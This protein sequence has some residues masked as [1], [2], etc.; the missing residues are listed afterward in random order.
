MRFL[1][2]VAWRNIFRNKRRTV[3]ASLAIGIGLAAL[4]FTDGLIIGMSESMIRTATDT[5]LGHAQIHAAEFR[6]TQ[7]VE[8]TINDLPAV[9]SSLRSDPDVQSF[10]E[11][12]QAFAMLSSASSASAVMLYGIAPH[13]EQSISRIDEALVLGTFLAEDHHILIGEKLA[14]TLEVQLGDRVVI[15]VAQAES[16]ELAQEMFRVG[17]VFRFNNR[18]LD[19]AVAFVPLDRAQ[20]LLGLGGRV[21]EIA[22]QFNDIHLAE[23]PA[24]QTRYSQRDNEALSWKALMPQ[25]DAAVQMS[26]FSSFV[27]GFILFAV[28]SLGIM[29]T[30]FMSLYERMFEFGVLRAIG[31]RPIRIGLMILFEAGSL[32]I[33]SIALG[34][35]IGTL[36]TWY[37]SVQGIDYVGIEFAG[38]TFRDLIYPALNLRQFTLFPICVFL[39][40]FVA[41]L[42]PAIYAA[43]LTPAKAMQTMV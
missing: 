31:T 36:I 35:C 23:R 5:F 37:Y 32:S 27:V 11:R 1:L 15:T 41:G 25:L 8:R 4:I 43:R 28:V 38:V 14:R 18:E 39:F 12:I 21:H 26:S 7:E 9:I 29:N 3:L 34:M 20:T 42:Y 17:G 6:S 40:T 19:G 30:L 10:T 22:V 13:T 16:G 24:F 2:Q 33:I